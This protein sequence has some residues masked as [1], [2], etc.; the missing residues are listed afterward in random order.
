MRK[1]NPTLNGVLAVLTFVFILGAS[2]VYGEDKPPKTLTFA[3]PP[4]PI[5]AATVPPTKIGFMLPSRN[6]LRPFTATGTVQVTDQTGATVILTDVVGDTTLNG[7]DFARTVQT[8]QH[9][10]GQVTF[11]KGCTKTDPYGS[12]NCH[13]DWGQSVTAAFQGALQEDIQAGKLIVDLKVDTTIPF[14]FSCP[15]C[16]ASCTITVPK[17]VDDGKFNE[18]WVLMFGLIR[19]PLTLPQL[20]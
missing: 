1:I 19:L 8:L 11:D 14:Q 6:P 17:Q 4:C 16:G 20:F 18:L 10:T 2:P 13:W 12:T 5:K 3:M 9:A 15:V 7:V